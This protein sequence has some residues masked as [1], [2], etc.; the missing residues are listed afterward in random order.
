MSPGILLLAILILALVCVLPAWGHSKNWGFA[1]SG[2]FGLTLLI[3]IVLLSIG[4]V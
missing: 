3:W 4:K 1:P 2:G